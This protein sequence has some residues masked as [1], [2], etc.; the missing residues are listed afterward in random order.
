MKRS[1][2]QLVAGAVL[3]ASAVCSPNLDARK[4]DSRRRVSFTG[5]I[6][7]NK[8]VGLACATMCPVDKDPVYTLQTSEGAWVLSDSK[9]AAQLA[10]KFAGQQVIVKGTASGNRLKVESVTA[11]N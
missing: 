7:D 1:A 3:F 10:A 4:L 6:R 9:Q 11:A 8:C 2:L 5:T